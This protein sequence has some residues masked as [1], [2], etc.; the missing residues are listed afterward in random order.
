MSVSVGIIVSVGNAVADGMV[1]GDGTVV[2]V[3]VAGTG[4]FVINT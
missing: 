4:V 3:M 1:V 2:A